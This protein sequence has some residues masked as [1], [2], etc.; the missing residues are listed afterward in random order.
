MRVLWS[1]N[2]TSGSFSKTLSSDTRPCYYGY[3]SPSRT[4]FQGTATASCTVSRVWNGADRAKATPVRPK[5]QGLRREYVIPVKVTTKR[6]KQKTILVKRHFYERPI[7]TRVEQDA[8]NV[9]HAYTVTYSSKNDVWTRW[10]EPNAPSYNV[11]GDMTV[12]RVSG[13]PTWTGANAPPVFGANE[14]LTLVNKL[15]AQIRGSDF[16]L[17][18]FLGEGHE[19]I[20]MITST[21][22]K[23]A[24]AGMMAR[25]GRFADAARHL[26][27]ARGENFFGRSKQTGANS[28]LEL[29]YGWLPLLGDIKSGAEQLAHILHYP[30]TKTYRARLALRKTYVPSLGLWN[31]AD[32]HCTVSRQIIAHITEPESTLSTS[33]LLDPELVAWELLPFSFVADW[34]IPVGDYLEARA[35]SRRLSGTFVT[36]DKSVKY[37]FNITNQILSGTR[38]N[39]V[40]A[41]TASWRETILTRS[42][43]TTLSVPFPTVKPVSQALSWRHMLN[44]LALT[45]QVFK[46]KG[47]DKA[48]DRKITTLQKKANDAWKDT[49]VRAERRNPSQ[50]QPRVK[51]TVWNDVQALF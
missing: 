1:I 13:W 7:P 30:K 51:P 37:F 41:N 18:V 31:W 21:A 46:G 50:I 33:G 27:D 12:L 35:F 5:P 16:N 20:K 24:A 34:F 25:K 10:F 14:Q 40:L 38:K 15:K 29:Q 11:W 3:T 17:A 47:P 26:T 43:S 44:A 45:V 49:V 48:L 23:V 2:M 19:T 36:T 28:W 42:I 39:S 22:I 8:R 32:A 6:G 9:P 4:E